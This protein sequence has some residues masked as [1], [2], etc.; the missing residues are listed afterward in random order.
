MTFKQLQVETRVALI[1]MLWHFSNS[2]HAHLALLTMVIRFSIS[3]KSTDQLTLATVI[4]SKLLSTFHTFLTNWLF[5][6]A[7]VAFYYFCVI[8]WK[9]VV[10]RFVMAYSAWPKLLAHVT[11]HLTTS[12]V[13]PTPNWA[14]FV[15]FL[16]HLITYWFINPALRSTRLKIRQTSKIWKLWIIIGL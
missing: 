8:S 10:F 5:E 14:R 16:K 1:T 11:H 6:F 7:V 15:K 4:L 3:S 12:D 2:N 9:C 13:M